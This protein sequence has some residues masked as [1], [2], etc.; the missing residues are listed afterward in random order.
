MLNQ[1]KISYL[2]AFSNILFLFFF[3]VIRILNSVLLMYSSDRIVDHDVGPS[4]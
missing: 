3:M 4:L 1:Q 2:Y